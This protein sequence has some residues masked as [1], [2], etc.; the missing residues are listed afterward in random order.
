MDTRMMANESSAKNQ[1]LLNS[2][3]ERVAQLEI[4]ISE[5][6]DGTKT[7]KSAKS[8]KKSRPK[9]IQDLEEK[10]IKIDKSKPTA[11]LQQKL[12]DSEA[13]EEDCGCQ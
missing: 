13:A 9:V 2:L 4:R 6:E 12:D 11:E 10:N 8:G 7:V 1:K 3:A 5:L